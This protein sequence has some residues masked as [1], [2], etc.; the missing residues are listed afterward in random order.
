MDRLHDFGFLIKEVS[1]RYVLRFEQRARELSLTL[2]QCKALVY[3]E[4]NEGVSQARLASLTDIEPMTIVRILDR[5]EADCV[6]ERR[7]DPLD[8]RARR[9]YL[10]DKATPLLEEIWRL[11]DI[12]RFE[13]FAGIGAQERKTFMDVL[14]RLHANAVALDGQ[15]IE[16][17][18]DSPQD[19]RA[20]K[21]GGASRNSRAVA[22]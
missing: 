11:V 10:T 3:L 15:S 20:T 9:L 12:T 13:M 19:L 8:R 18:D 22:R 21:R 14:Q 16:A 2:P 6:L 4:E 17:P 5:M 7:A 1:R